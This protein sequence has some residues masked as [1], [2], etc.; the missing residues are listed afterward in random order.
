MIQLADD[1]TPSHH[2]TVKCEMQKEQN[3]HSQN[4]GHIHDDTQTRLTR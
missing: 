1:H 2:N 4:A 3:K